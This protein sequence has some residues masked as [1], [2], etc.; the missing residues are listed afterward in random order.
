VTDDII[1]NLGLFIFMGFAFLPVA[2]RVGMGG[3]AKTAAT[4]SRTTTHEQNAL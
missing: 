2:I 3:S 4:K 1:N